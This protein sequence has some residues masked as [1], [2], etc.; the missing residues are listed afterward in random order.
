MIRM[1]GERGAVLR[2]GLAVGVCVFLCMSAPAFAAD[3]DES[4]KKGVVGA[5]PQSVAGTTAAIAVPNFITYRDRSQ[6]SNLRKIVV[7]VEGTSRQAKKV[8]AA[9]DHDAEPEFGGPLLRRSWLPPDWEGG[10]MI[11]AE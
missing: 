10:G 5:A 7:F 8:E 4:N 1:H 2:R 9:P 11:D 3:T 6:V